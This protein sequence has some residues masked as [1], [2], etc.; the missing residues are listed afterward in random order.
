MVE[1]HSFSSTPSFLLAKKLKALKKTLFSG[2]AESL[3]M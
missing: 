2:T 3:V 1:S